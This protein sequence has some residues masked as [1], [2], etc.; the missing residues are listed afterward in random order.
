MDFTALKNKVVSAFE[1]KHASK[2][3]EPLKL[4]S[5]FYSAEDAQKA[6]K[7]NPDIPIIDKFSAGVH[8]KGKYA[9]E[10]RREKKAYEKSSKGGEVG[11]YL[12][13]KWAEDLLRDIF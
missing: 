12:S 4:A 6:R 13:T 5:G 3:P 11:N 9:E 8:E 2:T 1:P 10:R 7:A